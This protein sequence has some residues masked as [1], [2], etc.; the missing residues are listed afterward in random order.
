M[1]SPRVIIYI[2]TRLSSFLFSLHKDIINHKDILLASFF[3][4]NDNFWIINIYSD[5]SHFA[6]KYLKDS[7]ANIQNLLIM[8]G[9]FNIWDSIWNLSFPHYFSISNNLIIIADSFNLDLSVLTNSVPTRYPDTIGELNSVINLMFLQS[10]L[11]E[12][13]NH[14]IHPG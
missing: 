3:N 2:S 10:G 9:G 8:T 5:S 14:S 12:L 13:N 7:E 11:T 6:L 4:N 1:T